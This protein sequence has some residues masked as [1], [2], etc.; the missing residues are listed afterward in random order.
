M[1]TQP[2]NDAIVAAFQ[3]LYTVASS[4]EDAAQRDEAI[5]VISTL[6]EEMASCKPR[7]YLLRALL[8]YLAKIPA[9]RS[10]T[11]S[12]WALVGRLT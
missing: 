3:E 10:L 5:S 9:L 2:L 7:L 6:L 12:A 8:D 4:L 1:Q 11:Q